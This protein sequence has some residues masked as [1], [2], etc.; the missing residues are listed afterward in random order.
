MLEIPVPVRFD[1]YQVARPEPDEM[2]YD[3]FP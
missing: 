1:R 2:D 3:S